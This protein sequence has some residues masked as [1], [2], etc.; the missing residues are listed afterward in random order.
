MTPAALP[1]N[2]IPQDSRAHARHSDG[3][4]WARHLW[5][6]PM[7]LSLIFVVAVVVWLQRTDTLDR[8]ERRQTMITDALT[9]EAQL[10]GQL[11]FEASRLDEI[12]KSLQVGG[13]TAEQ[14]GKNAGISAGFGRIWQAVTWLDQNNRVIAHVASPS[15]D[16]SALIPTT[17]T[18]ESVRGIS[19]HLV[20]SIRDARGNVV[21]SLVAR[22]SPTALLKRGVP[23]WLARKYRVSLTDSLDQQLAASEDM[24]RR[25]ADSAPGFLRISYALSFDPPIR[26]ASLEL[27]E[28]TAFV[29]W[30]RGLPPAL[31][32]GFL[33]LVLIA[34]WMLR[35]QMQSVLRAESAWRTEAAWRSAM[36][37]SMVVGL[38]ARDFNG[39]L[40]Y[41]NRT[42]AEMVGWSQD[43][44]I[45]MMTPM[46]YWP[47]DQIEETM[48]RHLRNMAGDAP[49]EGYEARW[50]HRDGHHLD[51]MVF[52]TPL[53]DASGAQIG[54]MGSIL[55]ITERKLMEERD[56]K[57]ADTLAHHARLTMLGEIASTLA[58]ELNQPLTAIASYNAGVINS[59]KRDGFT[60]TDV[61]DALQ[62]LGEQAAQAGRIVQRI[63]EFLTRREPERESCEIHQVVV[64]AIKLFRREL[65]RYDVS[66]TLNNLDE[67]VRVTAD[68]VLIE[69]VIINLLRNATDVL[70][71]TKDRRIEVTIHSAGER[72]LRI[73]V[74]DNGPGL[75]G[76]TIKQLCTAFYSTKSDG[77]G[78][79]LAICRS[80]IEAHEGAFD[81]REAPSNFAKSG[82]QFSFSLPLVPNARI[83]SLADQDLH[84]VLH[85]AAE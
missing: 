83:S 9:L 57:Q 34:T 78:M 15:A 71:S 43:A 11:D 23:W 84:R 19:S 26:D 28:H 47:P 20:A 44:L 1:S 14:F 67:S 41:V 56:R 4:F 12:G 77:M 62:R 18:A 36:E 22:Y 45:G 73:D 61:H 66:V 51:V 13:V 60:D 76:R 70:M 3:Q 55:E 50:L 79:G 65:D 31:M 68:P 80:I 54:W 6:L 27:T 30:Y 35:R 24:L 25:K 5:V 17:A 7:L 85:K 39:R 72:F 74:T 82:A 33:L 21:G 32:A 63:R 59:L 16:P 81:A 38:R 52:E 53:V 37:D 8:E 64:N 46:P 2:H 58:H 42:F 10:R 69:Q 49:R 40:V 29:P 75:A 48:Q